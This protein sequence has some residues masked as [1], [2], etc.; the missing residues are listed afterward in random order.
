MN[1][2]RYVIKTKGKENRDRGEEWKRDTGHGKGERRELNGEKKGRKM[3]SET[4]GEE[5]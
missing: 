5:I 2:R 3:L 4:E 1:R